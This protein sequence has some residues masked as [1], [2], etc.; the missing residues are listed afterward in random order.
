ML[1]FGGNPGSATNLRG[2]I[3][4]LDCE[5]AGRLIDWEVNWIVRLR[6]GRSEDRSV[7]RLISRQFNRL[8]CSLLAAWLDD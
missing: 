8:V 7:D 1:A 4:S 6:A 5:L 3:I 2:S